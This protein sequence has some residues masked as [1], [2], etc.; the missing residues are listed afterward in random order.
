MPLFGNE[1]PYFRDATSEMGLNFLHINGFSQRRHIV[2]TMGSGGALFDYDNDSDLDLYLV[3]GNRLY[4]SDPNI[5]NCLYRNDG[6]RFVDV[7]DQAK[8][9]D[10]GYGMGAVA[11]DYNDDGYADLYVTNFGQ[12]VLYR[13]N[14]DG[15]FSDATMQAK[16]ECS[17]LSSS[18]AFAD[19]DRDGDLDLYVCNYAEY[20]LKTEKPC[21]H[22]KLQIYCGPNEYK[23]ISDTFYLNNGDG[24]FSDITKE[25]GVYEPTT[26][27]LGVVFSDVN[28]DGWLD[29]YVANDMTPNTLFINQKN[30]S[31]K[32]EGVL[33]GVAY[34][35]DGIAN[36]SMGI[37]SADYDNDG[38]FDLWVT[39]FS[40]EANSLMQN[41]GRGFF[42]DA[43]FES[44]LA[45]PS[46][47]M[48]G[49]GTRFLDFDNDGWLDLFV[50]NGHIWDNVEQ[51]D[52]TLS[53]AQPTQL[54]R[55]QNG[56]FFEITEEAGLGKNNYVV[57][58]ML[59]GDIDND[60]DIDTVLCQSNRQA[61][62][63]KNEIGN[64][65]KW[66]MLKLIGQGGNRDAI[67]A[68]VQL[69][70]NGMTQSREV[71]CGASYLSGNDLRLF[72]GVKGANYVD[73]LEIRW[74]DGSIQT[75]ADLLTE[76]LLIIQQFQRPHIAL[77]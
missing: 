24:T 27:G 76:R 60:G 75:L 34:N 36:G 69:V 45:E 30:G 11:A 71:I 29:I 44:G 51:I 22:G 4:K 5:T 41:D 38:D 46:F 15:T 20:S 2:E 26:R 8:V 32:E 74:P 67:G 7:T 37:D 50:G 40:L 13:N 61:V 72:F 28:D 1:P 33:R 17:L 73:R 62:I 66:L 16:V 42:R 55:N 23:G 31:F 3:Q 64:R 53:Y 43:T 35:D 58:G 19:F 39:N 77:P 65:Q 52:P 18:A 21:Y 59:F 14:G 10:I 47:Y 48:L 56:K 70:A 12:N 6:K 68:K 63:L 49:F 54:F 9:G 25:A 57:R